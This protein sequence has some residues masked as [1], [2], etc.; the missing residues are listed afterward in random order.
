L[1]NPIPV[2]TFKGEEDISDS[3]WQMP[4]AGKRSKQTLEPK[5]KWVKPEDTSLLSIPIA[6]D[7]VEMLMTEKDPLDTSEEN[8]SSVMFQT[9]RVTILAIKTENMTLYL[10]QN[11]NEISIKTEQTFDEY[12]KN[13]EMDDKFDRLRGLL[14]TKKRKIVDKENSDDTTQK[15]KNWSRPSHNKRNYEPVEDIE[16]QCYYCSEMMLRSVV[17]EHMKTFHGCYI[18]KNTYQKKYLNRPPRNMKIELPDV[19]VEVQCY[20]CSE[21]MMRS[22]VKEHMKTSHGRYGVKMFG[23]KRQ[24]QCLDCHAALLKEITINHM[25][26]TDRLQRKSLQ[27]SQCSKT[28][29][30]VKGLEFH[31]KTSHCIQMNDQLLPKC[32]FQDKL[33]LKVFDKRTF[34]QLIDNLRKMFVILLWRNSKSSLTSCLMIKNLNFSIFAITLSNLSNQDGPRVTEV[35]T[36]CMLSLRLFSIFK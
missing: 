8:Y 14:S 21:M 12:F 35:M 2:E 7:I 17:T 20:Y 23:E 6:A 1:A 31:M 32:H 27:C 19:D 10:P 26:F 9:R 5:V 13:E 18:I 28:F 4:P 30:Q 16:V 29:M 25:C 33:S 22:V 36:E 34:S 15:K 3:T 11:L 24:F